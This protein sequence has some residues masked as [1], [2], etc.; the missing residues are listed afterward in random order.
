MYRIGELASLANVSKRTIDY[1]TSLGLL[2]ANRSK[3]NYRIYSEDSLDTLKFIEK[4]KKLHL[5]LEE[6]KRKLEIKKSREIKETEVE[7]QIYALAQQMKQLQDELSDLLPLIEKLD[8][9]PKEALAK[10][11]TNERSALLQSL[12]VI[13]S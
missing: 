9:K 10:K 1:Y 11:L 8:D 13:T 7:K 4:Y 3:S 5:P 2:E 6:I 12:L